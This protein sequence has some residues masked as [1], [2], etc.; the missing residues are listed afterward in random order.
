MPDRL[1]RFSASGD[2]FCLGHLIQAAIAYYRATDD[3]RLLNVLIPYV[4]N[5]VARFGS[6]KQPCWSGHPEIE[7]ALVELYRTTGQKKYL[8]FVRFLLDKFDYRK[9]ARGHRI[10]FEHYF[11]GVPFRSRRELSGHAVCAMYACCGATDYYLE[12]GKPEIWH[13]LM[14]LWDDLTRYKMYVTGGVGSRPS[15]E[16]IGDRYELPNERGYAETCAAIGNMMWNWRLLQ[17]SG[18]AHFADVMELALYNGVLSGVSLKGDKYFYWNPLL[19]RLNPVRRQKA[20][21]DE[22]LLALKKTAGISLNVRQPYY[23]TPC[24][25]PNIQR[26]IASV[27]GYMYSTSAEGV[28]VHLYHSSRLNWRLQSDKKLTLV[29][30]TNYPWENNVKITFEKVPSEDFSLFLRIPGWTSSARV[31]I[32]ASPSRV[33]RSCGSYYEIRRSWKKG[34][35][36]EIVFEMPVRVVHANPR[37]RQD[38]GRVAIQRGP[39]IYCLESVDHPNVSIFDVVLPLDSSGTFEAF[40]A[41]FMP[42][43]LG[44]VVAITGDALAYGSPEVDEKLYGFEPFSKPSRKV[45]LT[46]IPYFAWAHR[47]PSE[48]MVWIPCADKE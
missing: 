28:W 40:E 5:V 11:S 27:P 9:M 41:Q 3:E 2:L 37:V 42:N 38:A 23:R 34:D 33:V 17:A 13:A 4:D 16:A 24:C 21:D 31:T 43:L 36:V 25:I 7:M 20:G 32:N 8:D 47:G 10:D 46:A 48:M 12:T 29:Q 44:G 14:T 45:T 6:G 35:R 18:E 26:T 39:L 30:D 22:D 15:N 1:A 19:S